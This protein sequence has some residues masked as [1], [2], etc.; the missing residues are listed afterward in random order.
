MIIGVTGAS[1]QLGRLVVEQLK[2]KE[3]T[4]NFIALVRTP[5]KLK[6]LAVASRPFDYDHPENMAI[7]LDGIDHLLLISGSEIGQRA[8]QHANV[9][10]EAKRAGV[11]WIVYT[12]LLHADTSSLSLAREHF[13]TEKEIFIGRIGFFGFSSS[14]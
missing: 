5:E 1:G 14:T 13:E 7:S 4:E 8:R 10:K 3:A 12:S 6:G 9:I 2:R 11:K